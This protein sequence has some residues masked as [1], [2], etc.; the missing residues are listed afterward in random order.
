[1]TEYAKIKEEAKEIM[2]NFMESLSGIDVEE[3]FLLERKVC[4]REEKDSND[5]NSEFRNK[6]LENA[7]RKTSDAILANKGE[8]TKNE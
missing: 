6:F 8:W 3:E 4:L 1:M 2:D 5:K 7:P